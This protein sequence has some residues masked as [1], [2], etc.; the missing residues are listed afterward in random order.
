M[1]LRLDAADRLVELVEERRGP[2]AAE[3]AARRLFALRSAPVGL[4]RS[5][6]G[7]VVAEDA[8]LAWRGDCVALV[9][10]LGAD[11]PLERATYVVVDLETTGLRPG[12]A[13]ICEIGAVR[14]REL[15]FAGEFQTLVDPGVPIGAA[16]AALTGL[17]DAQLRGAPHPA[18]AVRRL[19]AFAEH[20]VLVAH[21]AR[22]DL[23]FLDRE[24]ERL[25]GARLACPVVD[26][27][28]LARRLLAGRTPRAG[29]ASLARFFGTTATPCHRAL[30]DAQ[31]TA[32]I[33]LHLLGLAQERGARTV[34]DLAELAAPRSRK[35]Y[36]KRSLAFGAPTAPGV[37]LF[38]D[39]NDQVLYVGRARDLR[40][41]LRSYFRTDRQRPAVE[42][43]LAALERIEWR[44]TGS[45]LEAA[46]EELRLI[47]ELHPPANARGVRPNRYVYLRRRGGSLVCTQT[48]TLL[49]P[50]RSRTRAR[51]ACRALDGAS[52]AEL[53]NPALALPRLRT[54]LRDLA[55]CRRY[56]DA[57]RLRDRI[58][59]LEWLVRTVHRIE[60]LRRTRACIVVPAR[61]PGFVRAYF[62]ADGRIAA[63]RLLPPGDGAR[64]EIAAG[65]A[66]VPEPS[67]VTD[68]YLEAESLD[69]LMLVGTFL[70]R[71]P[72]ELRVAR[73]DV[74]DI[75]RSAAALRA[76]A[77]GQVR[78]RA[79]ARAA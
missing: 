4:A 56:E 28:G 17:R 1:Q 16:I 5:L 6:L 40:A 73:L 53:E 54:K 72:P 48:P 49:G 61:E 79:R 60:R 13:R 44:I 51:L 50:L 31:A 74:D 47:R 45:E 7:E 32:E 14:V 76:Q 57:A 78:T 62:L 20:A 2:V 22:F 65:L 3:E 33:L 34:A 46:L 15:E 39:R 52:D 38:H 70:R 35:V 24:A 42:G 67:Q 69:D 29:L 71:P 10:P 68:C 59:A 58:A 37:Y 25:T 36:A 9:E 66:T 12:T 41:R 11:L 19:L 21:N 63:A 23:A 77:A 18:V 64:V 55:D 75:L 27:V 30:P 26:T 43:A 8:R